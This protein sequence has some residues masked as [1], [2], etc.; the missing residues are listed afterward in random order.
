M[1][2][3]IE[4]KFLVAKDSLGVMFRAS[5]TVRVICRKET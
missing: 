5:D 2:V 4:R 1:P 3:K